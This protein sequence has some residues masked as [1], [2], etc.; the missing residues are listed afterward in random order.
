MYA[1]TSYEETLKADDHISQF[2]DDSESVSDDFAFEIP[3]NRKSGKN[4]LNLS[5]VL[6]LT[7][8]LVDLDKSRLLAEPEDS[9]ITTPKK[10]VGPV[11]PPPPLPKRSLQVSTG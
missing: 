6:I 7:L 3:D 8:L 11:G 4:L 5:K 1:D 10:P 2:V 9:D